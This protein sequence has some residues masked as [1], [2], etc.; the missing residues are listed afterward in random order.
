[1]RGHTRT[2]SRPPVKTILASV[3]LSGLSLFVLVSFAEPIA[4]ALPVAA[5]LLSA[6][7]LWSIDRIHAGITVCIPRTK[8]CLRTGRD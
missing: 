7:L 2:S 4:V 3:V 8:R 6:A 1:M 5:T